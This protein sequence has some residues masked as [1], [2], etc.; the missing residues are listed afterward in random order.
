MR[1]EEIYQTISNRKDFSKHRSQLCSKDNITI[2]FLEKFLHIKVPNNM[3]YI[4]Y[5][6]IIFVKNSHNYIT[7]KTK[8]GNIDLFL[9]THTLDIKLKDLS[10][11]HQ[12]TNIGFVEL[13]R[14]MRFAKMKFISTGEDKWLNRQIELE[15]KVDEIILDTLNPKLF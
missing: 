11:Q 6:I 3:V 13:V 12:I 14:K 10:I 9:G 15:K 8:Y 4:E 7:F 2:D 1:K 5:G